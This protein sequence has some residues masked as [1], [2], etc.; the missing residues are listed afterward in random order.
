MC[1]FQ[2]RTL[3]RA[4]EMLTHEIRTGVKH[5]FFE[6]Q[7]L[8]EIAANKKRKITIKAGK[9]YQFYVPEEELE[10]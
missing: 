2:K 6:Y 5:G 4:L 10:E 9:S 7:I 8:C 1:E 3:E